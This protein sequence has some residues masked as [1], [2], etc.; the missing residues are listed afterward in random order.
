MAEST[1]AKNAGIHAAVFERSDWWARDGA[2]R[3]LHDINPLRLGWLQRQ[4]A[5]DNGLSGKR[6]LD[7]GCGGGIFSEAAARAGATVSAMDCS[8]AAIEAARQ[9]A[10]AAGLKID[11]QQ[12][13]SVADLP[14]AQ[15]EVI[16]CFELLEH[17]D[18]PAAL[19]HTLAERLTP[20]GLLAFSTINRT[21]RA[22]LL[23]VGAL[24]Y[25][26]KIIPYG[27]HDFRRFV[28]PEELARACRYSGLRVCDIQGMSY[29]F[30]GRFYRLSARQTAVNYFL[31][32]RRID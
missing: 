16:T 24:E 22:W 10:A 11:Y 30:F 18:D 15:Y 3:L 29:S 12:A 9:H 21:A 2:F 14:P 23:M 20:G 4:L 27:T 1:A 5:G 26:A 8:A 13:E 31:S 32:A 19:V 7:V 25:A 28:T 6:L 17:V